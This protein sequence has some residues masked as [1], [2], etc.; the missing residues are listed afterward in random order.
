MPNWRP[1]PKV[2]R[3]KGNVRVLASETLGVRLAGTIAYRDGILA[4]FPFR[5]R[6]SSL[7][8]LHV[9]VQG[10]VKTFQL[11]FKNHSQNVLLST[12]KLHYGAIFQPAT[13]K[14]GRI[15]FTLLSSGKQ[16]ALGCVIP[17]PGHLWTQGRIHGT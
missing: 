7:A 11:S 14:P 17:R 13:Q 12:L 6:G 3:F 1:I 2:L 9:Y 15:V 8:T 4:P 10:C 16:R 5:Y